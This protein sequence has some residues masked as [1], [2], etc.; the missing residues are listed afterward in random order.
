MPSA[1]QIVPEHQY[2]H[3]MV[4]END[5]SMAPN[6]NDLS[7]LETYCDMMFVFASPKGPDREFYTVDSG[8]DGF[9][10]TYGLGSYE[11][12]G[13]A[14]LNAYAAAR[15][16]AATLHCLRVSAKDATYS[17]G[18]LVAHYK[19][20]PA[21]DADVEPDE[22]T[23]ASKYVNV[24]GHEG[25]SSSDEVNPET[26]ETIIRLA[27]TDIVPGISE[28]NKMLFGD[29]KGQYVD[30]VIDFAQ[31]CG[32][33]ADSTYCVVQT[34]AALAEYMGTDPYITQEAG[35]YVK[36]KEYTGAQLMDGYAVLVGD[37]DPVGITIVKVVPA[38]PP[39]PVPPVTNNT[40]LAVKVGD[41]DA[42][43][44]VTQDKNG[45]YKVS[46]S[47]ECVPSMQF[48]TLWGVVDRTV[49]DV[50]LRLPLPNDLT[51]Y[52]VIQHNPA[53]GIYAG[54]ANIEVS[55]SGENAIYTKR[56][57]NTGEAFADGFGILLVEKGNATVKFFKTDDFTDEDTSTPVLEIQ[58]T[59][60]YTYVTEHT[61]APDPG[62]EYVDPVSCEIIPNLAFVGTETVTAAYRATLS[63]RSM[64]RKA[65]RL[66]EEEPIEPPHG[67]MNVY[68]TFEPFD[69]VTDYAPET[70]G[71]FVN[72]PDDVD[73]NG[74]HAV[75]LIEFTARF[76]GAAGDN[77]RF[78]LT[79]YARGDKLNGHYKTYNLYI[80]EIDKGQLFQKEQYTVSMNKK[81]VD[82]DGSTLFLDFLIGDPNFSSFYMEAK[83]NPAGFALLYS[84]YLRANPTSSVKLEEFDPILGRQFSSNQG[85]LPYLTID[86]VS[87]GTVAP[88]GASG[89]ALGGGSEGS[90]AIGTPGREK[91]LQE[92]YAEAYAGHTD[93]LIFSRKLFPTDLVMD[94]NFPA[95]T[96]LIISELN[97]RREDH[98][99]FYDLGTEFNTYE[100]LLYQ[101]AEIEDYVDTRNEAIEAYY[102]KIQ[103]PVTFEIIKVTSTYP[104]SFMYPTH[105]AQT[106]SKH[107]A[108]AGSAYG[109]M[110][111][112][113]NKSA[114]PV[115]D[116]DID[117]EIMDDLTERR[118]NFLKVNTLKQVVRG[119]QTTRQA[120]ETNLSECSNVFVL[121]DI[122]RD[123]VKICEQFEYNFAEASDLQRFN[124]QAAILCE[125][126]AEA[127][128]SSINA[129]FEMNDWEL[130]RGILHLYVDFV[131]KRLVKRAIVEIDINRGKIVV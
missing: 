38:T 61:P 88:S 100:G 74:Y 101:L 48:P 37:D 81:A 117:S 19:V 25:I 55:G 15:T 92:A 9:I 77:L 24:M 33:D 64:M 41:T 47:G 52:T 6:D 126:Y 116:D 112:F 82:K 1:T 113:I 67:Q 42:K 20:D 78:V 29:V 43:I 59:N 127:Q 45:V 110:T 87:P 84:E 51:D 58:V 35:V 30:V 60:N 8:Y 79:N 124:A 109:V 114:Y 125:K 36:K 65:A 32:L 27:G 105:F 99:T 14:Y 11:D 23:L 128:V 72:V 57:Q 83:T 40:D 94:A 50:E 85:L 73:E 22:P 68:Y 91:A 102:G 21:P 130:E 122:R 104:L 13:Q 34:N 119:A 62:M 106:R 111:G 44:D 63:R 53:L 103:D 26:G 121:H 12:Y 39:E 18:A 95:E 17:G 49:T 16:N 46:M 89:I 76:R 10:E 120:V 108:M 123:C 107:V 69:G 7:R 71:T 80:Y 31:L 86:A 131:H 93:R 5:N 129:I 98:M 118:V 66:A 90:F 97:H 28:D 96:K 115:Y 2:A 75:K 3:V 54:D 4:R 70:L 56:S